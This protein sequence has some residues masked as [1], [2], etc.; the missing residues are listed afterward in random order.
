MTVAILLLLALTICGAVWLARRRRIARLLAAPLPD[1]RRAIA[2]DRVPVFSKLPQRHRARLEGLM[3]RFLDQTSF[4]GQAGLVVTEEMR[5]VVAAQACLLVVGRPD[6]WYRSLR[7]IHLYPGGFRSPLAK[8][9]GHVVTTHKTARSGESWA[10]GPVVLSWEHAAYGAF[11]PNDGHNVVFHEFAHQLDQQTGVVDGAPLLGE[12]HDARAWAREMRAAYGRL[13]DDVESGRATFL[14]PY[15]ATAPAEFFAVLTEYFFE[16][17]EKL[18]AREP[19][20]YE[21][22]ATY[23]ALDPASWG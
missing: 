13:T 5:V 21:Q 3:N 23:Y 11:I 7:T 9:D 18:K 14:D 16:K 2:Q 1:A 17:P 6:R 10:H 20:L 19:A 12:D 4:H 8:T 15:G 22:L